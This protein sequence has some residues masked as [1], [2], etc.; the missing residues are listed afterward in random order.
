MVR[1]FLHTVH[2]PVLECLSPVHN[3]KKLEAKNT[4]LLSK[5]D[6]ETGR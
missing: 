6:K 5:L 2:N 1:A 4:E 3:W